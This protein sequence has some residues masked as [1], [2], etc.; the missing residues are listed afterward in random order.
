M[1][2]FSLAETDVNERMTSQIVLSK[3]FQR[4]QKD[5]DEDG[6]KTSGTKIGTSAFPDELAVLEMHN[7]TRISIQL[8]LRGRS[9]DTLMKFLFSWISD[10]SQK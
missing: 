1:L 9:F 4:S 3:G 8:L 6:R 2:I 5:E 7:R 10:H